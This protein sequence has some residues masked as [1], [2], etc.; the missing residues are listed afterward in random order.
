MGKSST[1]CIRYIKI[2]KPTHVIALSRLTDN[3][4]NIISQLTM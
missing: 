4:T 1:H 2:Y 3:Y